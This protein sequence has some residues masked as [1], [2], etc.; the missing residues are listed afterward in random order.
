VTA[1]KR[2][3]WLKR[4]VIA[5]GRRVMICNPAAVETG[6]NCLT[7]FCTLVWFQPPD[8]DPRAKR[9]AEGRVFESLGR[10]G[11]RFAGRRRRCRLPERGHQ[12][13]PPTHTVSPAWAARG[14]TRAALPSPPEGPRSPS[15]VRPVAS[16]KKKKEGH[17]DR[18]WRQ[19]DR[20]HQADD[21]EP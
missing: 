19:S 10:L 4:E 7:L 16:G 6:L 11:A 18:P 9:Q 14:R 17:F 20:V 2:E 12:L 15:P 3:A 13:E 5:K 8:C 21:S 1:R